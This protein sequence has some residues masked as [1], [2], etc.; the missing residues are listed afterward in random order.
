MARR[1]KPINRPPET[2]VSSTF[3]F[4]EQESGSTLLEFAIVA[5]VLFIFIFAIIEF[6][7]ALSRQLILEQALHVAGRHGAVQT[8]NCLD[9]SQ[10]RYMNYLANYRLI[11]T[12]R[13]SFPSANHRFSQQGVDYFRFQVSSTIPCITCGLFSSQNE[14]QFERQVVYPLEHPLSCF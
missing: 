4:F 9:Q 5:P 13:I 12:S 6:S 11:D 2:S 8:F 7:L 10:Q 14:F 1:A 3:R